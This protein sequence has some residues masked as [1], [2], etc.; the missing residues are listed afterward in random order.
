MT[1]GEDRNKDRLITESFA[2]IGLNLDRKIWQSAPLRSSLLHIC[3]GLVWCCRRWMD[4]FTKMK[5]HWWPMTTACL[6]RIWPVLHLDTDGYRILNFKNFWIRIGYGYAKNLS[7]MDQELKN[8][9]PLTSETN[10]NN[11]KCVLFLIVDYDSCFF[12]LSPPF[13]SIIF[14]FF[15]FF[16]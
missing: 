2:F 5:V 11:L 12:C 14:L 3:H 1:T 13:S 7:D 9:Y 4:K 10:T 15:A 8:Q 16:T 6:L